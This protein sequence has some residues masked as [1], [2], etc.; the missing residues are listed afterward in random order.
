MKATKIIF[1]FNQLMSDGIYTGGE[2]RG[3]IIATK[4]KKNKNFDV[5]VMIPEI[6]TPSFK[7]FKKIILGHQSFEKNINHNNLISAFIL[8][9]TRTFIFI[10][11]IPS[12][13]T[14]II[15]ATGDFICNIIPSFFL[16]VKFP[17]TKFVVCIHHINE[18]PFKRKSNY[19]IANVVSYC[20]QQTSF[21][22]IKKNA[23][24]I[25]VINDQVKDYFIKRKFKQKIVVVGN[26]LD[27]QEIKQTIDSL[28]NIKATNHISYFGRLSP[29]KGS[30]DLPIVLSNVLK[31]YPNTHLDIIGIAL[32]EI[33]KPLVEKFNKYQ[34]LGHYTIH[35]FIKDISDVYKIILQSKA[36]I[37]PSYEEGWA[38]SLFESIMSKRPVVAYKLPVFIKI[39]EDKLTT[40]NIG[41]TTAMAQKTISFI[42]NYS[43]LSTQKYIDSCYQIAKKYDWQNVYQLEKQSINNLINK[44][45][46]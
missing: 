34:C 8:Y 28:K 14:D 35:G 40:V 17:K 45:S 19:F 15:Y 21:F 44:Q 5:R 32:P 24:L 2:T 43:S 3:K 20:F 13:K 42:K 7:G 33:K 30:F 36:I 37:F 46:K 18:N 11:K 12:V 16:K 27:T 22:L 31:K 4:F 29:T 6:S 23:D 9:I 39:F 38:I 1:L 26:G 41:D 25:F 10:S